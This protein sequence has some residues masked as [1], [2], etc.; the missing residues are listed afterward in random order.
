MA[1]LKANYVHINQGFIQD[2]LPGG[3]GGGGGEG[4]LSSRKDQ[5]IYIIMVKS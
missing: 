4:I 1:V 5:F 3:G 2:F